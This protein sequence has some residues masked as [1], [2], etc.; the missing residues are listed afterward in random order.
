MS[1]IKEFQNIMIKKGYDFYLVP[2]A[3]YHNS[4][5]ISDYFKVRAFLSDFTG[6][7]GTLL[8]TQKNAYL[9]VDGRYFIQAAKQIEG[10]SITLMKMGTPNTPTLLE[11]L[12]ENVKANMKLVF[13]G[14]LVNT[15]LAR[16]IKENIDRNAII[17]TNDDTIDEIWE[18]RPKMPFSLLYMLDTFYTGK[19]YKEK[20]DEVLKKLAE[21]NVDTFILS[22]LEDQAWL[23]NLRANDVSH[24][25]VFLAFTVI[26]NN[27]VTLFIDQ[28]KLDI[29]VSK[30][31]YSEITEEILVS[32]GEEYV[33][34]Y[35][36]LNFHH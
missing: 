10:T 16:E 15:M 21:K 12:R 35:P 19:T 9:W 31:T 20:L 13:D 25:P 27:N 3:D 22:A 8:I 1:A 4:E 30:L 7:A 17:K 26:T 33:H 36:K 18:E 2:T 5:Y 6:S 14:K 29:K 28:R 11:F 24:T 23:F 34:E 32:Y